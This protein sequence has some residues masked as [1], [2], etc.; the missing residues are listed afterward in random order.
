MCRCIGECRIGGLS[1][2]KSGKAK[3]HLLGF[4]TH[5]YITETLVEE[6]DANQ[7][8][9]FKLLLILSKSIV[10]ISLRQDC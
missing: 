3:N 9:R 5:L 8:A 10:V 2:C 6:V 4:L 7:M 1:I